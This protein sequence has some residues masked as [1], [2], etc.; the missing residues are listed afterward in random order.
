[1]AY[2]KITGV[3][4]KIKDELNNI[5]SNAGIPLSQILKPKLREIVDSYPEDMKRIYKKR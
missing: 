3:S 4:Q 2:I 5:S 1:M